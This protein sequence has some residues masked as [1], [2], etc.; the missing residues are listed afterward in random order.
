MSLN[1]IAGFIP[2]IVFDL[3][4][5]TNQHQAIFAMIFVLIFTLATNYKYIKKFYILPC[6]TVLFFLVAVVTVIVF[7]INWIVIH[8]WI[9]TNIMLSLIA[10]G[11]ILLKKPF[12]IQYAKEQ[13][14]KTHWSHPI[15]IFI[16][17]FLTATWGVIFL[18][19][20]LLNILKANY[21]LYPIWVNYILINSSTIFGVWMCLWFPQWYPQYLKQ[22]SGDKYEST[23]N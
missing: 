12:T 3:L 10:W 13:V 14:P 9:A 8:T 20:L 22:K 2:W 11:S 5:K 23:C 16:N 19:H 18:L 4:P 1:L 21:A 7:R 6:A 15:F 17:N